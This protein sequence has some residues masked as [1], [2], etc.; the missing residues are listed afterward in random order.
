MAGR[1]AKRK[2]RGRNG[3]SRRRAA[4]GF[5]ATAGAFLAAAASP[6]ATAPQANADF[7]DLIVDLIDPGAFAAAAEA[8]TSSAVTA[9]AA[10]AAAV[11]SATPAAVADPSGVLDLS[12]LLTLLGVTSN[13]TTDTAALSNSFEAGF[14]QPVHTF[15]QDWINSPGGEYAD[16]Q[17]NAL[18]EYWFNSPGGQQ[19]DNEINQLAEYWINNAVGQPTN[20]PIN[21][22]LGTPPGDFCGLICNGAAGTEADPTGGNGGFCLVT[23]APAGPPAQPAWPAA[24]AARPGGSV[25]AV[26]AVPVGSAPMAV[27]A[28]PA[29]TEPTAETSRQET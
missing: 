8:A 29:A 4:L 9:P 28:A 2:A 6:F 21:G 13:G 12:A 1:H 24:T 10:L 19:I 15:I 22:L 3:K 14:Y 26:M 11:D 17:L 18:Y 7:E 27:V 20:I 5:S 23:A 16:N 25:T